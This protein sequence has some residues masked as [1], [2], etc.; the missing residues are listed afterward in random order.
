MKIKEIEIE[1]YRGFKN[2]KHLAFKND[3]NESGLKSHP[4]RRGRA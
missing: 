1:N 4:K 2:K 3:I